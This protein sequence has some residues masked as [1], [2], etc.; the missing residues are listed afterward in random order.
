[1]TNRVLVVDDV[2]EVRVLIRRVLAA[3][4]YE[5]SVAATVPEA[6]SMN[7]SSYDAVVVDAHVGTERGTDLVAE[8][9][10]Q[11]PA[12]AGKCL[13]VTGGTRDMLPRGVACLTKPFTPDQLLAAL[14][15]LHQPAIRPD[16]QQAE[17]IPADDVASPPAPDPPNGSRPPAGRS[18][19]RELLSIARNRRRRDRHALAA[20]MHDEP[21]QE[22]T[23]A[24]LELQMMRRSATPGQHSALDSALQRLHAATGSLR[25]L[26][27]TDS[28]LAPPTIGLAD[29][30]RGQ[31]AW[32]LAAPITVDGIQAAALDGPEVPYIADVV[33]LML[34]ALVP[35][36]LQALAHVAARAQESV[37]RI[38]LTATLAGDDETIGE[39]DTAQAALDRLAFAL[40]ADVQSELCD[41][42]W[43]VMLALAPISEAS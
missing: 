12:A 17:V 25:Q 11:D 8:L 29:A 37:I 27:E 24:T 31:T 2:H 6:R 42:E 40:G 22:L 4:G 1:V 15:A 10:A 39:P 21:I 20:F 18:G 36:G 32:L 35:A 33:E 9:L 23:A 28:P 16:R 13:I 7:P 3:G 14:R 43:R 38:E 26:V 19:A 5:V 41:R 30:L 34:L